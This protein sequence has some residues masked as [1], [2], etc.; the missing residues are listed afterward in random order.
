MQVSLKVNGEEH[1]LDVS[2]VSCWWISCED[3]GLTGTHVVIPLS[4]VYSPSRWQG[5]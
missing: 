4:A 1:N 2:R 3:L 5:S